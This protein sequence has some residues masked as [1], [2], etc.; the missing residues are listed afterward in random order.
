[1]NVYLLNFNQAAQKAQELISN[2]EEGLLVATA[3]SLAFAI[4]KEDKS[5]DRERI[6]KL[7]GTVYEGLWNGGTCVVFPEDISICLISHEQTNFANRVLNSVHTYLKKKGLKVLRS[8]NDL[9]IYP[10]D[11]LTG[12]KIASF[13]DS[14]NPDGT[15]FEAVVHISIGTDNSIIEQVCTKPMRKTPAALK[16]YGINTDEMLDYLQ[17]RLPEMRIMIIKQ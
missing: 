10:K 12:Y 5:C 16:D 1:M 7:G 17:K 8:G 13:G 11:A 2:N 6:A 15:Y 9:L 14:W 4:G 3:D